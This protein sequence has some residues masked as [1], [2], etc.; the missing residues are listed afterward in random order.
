[1]NLENHE[2]LIFRAVLD[3]KPRIRSR[4]APARN[5]QQMTRRAFSLRV[6]RVQAEL[7][8]GNPLSAPSWPS[9]QQ[10]MVFLTLN[11][12]SEKSLNS[13]EL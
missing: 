5:V 10:I 1:M 2:I 11:G 6:I 12:F 13:F 3:V 9:V 4:G 7:V 8:G